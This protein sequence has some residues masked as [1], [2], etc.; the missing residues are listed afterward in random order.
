MSRDAARFADH[1][2]R[3]A[4]LECRPGQSPG[5]GPFRPLAEPAARAWIAARVED[6]E[7]TPIPG[8][9]VEIELEGGPVLRGRTDQAGE[10]R[11]DDVEE[12]TGIARAV[13]RGPASDERRRR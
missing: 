4:C 5:T 9:E 7:G 6:A 11:F 12:D 10:V 8:E 3:Q 13:P 1:D 2:P